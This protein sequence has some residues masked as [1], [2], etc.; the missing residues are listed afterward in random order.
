MK[1]ASK[2]QPSSPHGLNE[3]ELRVLRR[4]NYEESIIR[5]EIERSVIEEEEWKALQAAADPEPFG[6]EFGKGSEGDAD[7]GDDNARTAE[8]ENDAECEA[9]ADDVLAAASGEAEPQKKDPFRNR[10]VVQQDDAAM[11][12]WRTTGLGGFIRAYCAAF[13]DIEETNYTFL[14]WGQ[15]AAV[16]AEFELRPV[17]N[18]RQIEKTCEEDLGLPFVISHTGVKR[19]DFYYVDQPEEVKRVIADDYTKVRQSVVNFL[20]YC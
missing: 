11:E 17:M 1:H 14:H 3:A 2:N 18:Q 12:V 7:D 6:D 4:M 19:F 10:E 15:I 5:D 16:L 13:V 8:T 20:W 9:N